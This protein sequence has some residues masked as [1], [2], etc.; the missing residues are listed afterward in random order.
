MLKLGLT[1][2]DYG[3]VLFGIVLM[4]AVSLIQ[5]KKGSIRELLWEK[6]LLRYVL[7][8]TLLVIT[9]LMGSYGIGYNASNF[10]YNQF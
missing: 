1:M 6:P 4:F 7:V 10:I 2:L 9:L 5:E 8:I 3:I